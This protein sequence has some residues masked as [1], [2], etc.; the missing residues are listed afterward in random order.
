MTAPLAPDATERAKD[1][2]DLAM[3]SLWDQGVSAAQIGEQVG[4]TRNVALSFVW[5]IHQSDPTALTR[6]PGCQTYR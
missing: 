1:E 2:R 3:L 5:R 4:V 6:K